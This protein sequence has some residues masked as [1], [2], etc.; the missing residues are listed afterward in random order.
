MQEQGSLRD[1]IIDSSLEIF[2]R[3]GIKGTDVQ[4]VIERAGASEDLFY[5]NFPTKDD[6]VMAFLHKRHDVWMGWF[7]KE[8]DWRLSCPGAGLEVIAD[9]LQSWFE[10]PAFR[11]CAFINTMAEGGKFDSESLTFAREHKEDLKQFL[12]TVAARLN[13]ESPEL[14]ASTAVLVV[15]GA[16]VRAQMTGDAREAYNARLL[17][18]CLNHSRISAVDSCSR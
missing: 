14:T 6:L 10:D 11:G 7:T 17:F 16:I 1:S 15:E 5:E 2:Y 18:Q 4:Q 8:V 9:V 12:K 3:D 13:H